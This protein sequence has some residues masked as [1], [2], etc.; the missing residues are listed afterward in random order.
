MQMKQSECWTNLHYIHCSFKIAFCYFYFI[1]R[2]RLKNIGGVY[3]WQLLENLGWIDLRLVLWAMCFFNP[4]SSLQGFILAKQEV[5]RAFLSFL[6]WVKQR[7]LWFLT[8]R[9]CQS[10]WSEVV[11]HPQWSQ[12]KL[13]KKNKQTVVSLWTLFKNEMWGQSVKWN[14]QKS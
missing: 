7:P 4:L 10:V 2:M 14:R 9:K 6:K 3:C 11:M 8:A 1:S 13:I 5:H 12:V